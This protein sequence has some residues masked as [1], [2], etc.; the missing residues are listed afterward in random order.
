[1]DRSEGN[2]VRL[3]RLLPTDSSRESWRALSVNAPRGF[4][5]YSKEKPVSDDVFRTFVPLFDYD[6]TPLN[7]R[8]LKTDS[9]DARFVKQTIEFDAPYGQERMRAFLFLPRTAAPPYKTVVF[10]PG[11]TALDVRSSA[12][13]EIIPDCGNDWSRAALP[14]VQGHIR[15]QN[16]VRVLCYRRRLQHERRP[17]RRNTYRDH[18]IMQVKDRDALSTT[19][20]RGPM[21]TRRRSPIWA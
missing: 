8:V 18:T 7:A 13:L 21:S 12:G 19:C 5:D 9:A 17:A 20:S 16:G 2:G 1:M 3:M 10:F 11:S 6:R 15:A 14:D 4:R